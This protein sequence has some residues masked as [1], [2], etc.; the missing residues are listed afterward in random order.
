MAWE[1][2]EGIIAGLLVCFWCDAMSGFMPHPLQS[3]RWVPRCWFFRD[4]RRGSRAAVEWRGVVGSDGGALLAAFG[5]LIL[6]KQGGLG[7][8]LSPGTHFVTWAWYQ[9]GPAGLGQSWARGMHA[10]AGSLGGHSLSDPVR[11]FRSSQFCSR[12]GGLDDMFL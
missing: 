6:T 1:F 2:V 11:F 10:S 5:M 9:G 8:R 4:E 7:I 3:R 12:E